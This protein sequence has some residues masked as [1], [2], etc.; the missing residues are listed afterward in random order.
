MDDGTKEE[1]TGLVLGCAEEEAVI[2][3]TI[4]M[5]TVLTDVTA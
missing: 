2:W 1:D 5:V 3:R 4:G